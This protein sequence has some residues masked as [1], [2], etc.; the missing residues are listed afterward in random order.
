MSEDCSCVKKSCCDSDGSVVGDGSGG[1]G[2]LSPDKASVILD[3][4]DGVGGSSG[5]DVSRKPDKLPVV[6]TTLSFKDIF[7]A[8]K[9]RWGIGRMSYKVE[10]GL[11][12]VGT[13]AGDSPVLVSANYKL[14]FDTLRQNLSG[15][16]CWLLI[17]D[18]KGVNVW[19]AAGKGTFGTD[20]LVKRV[21]AVGLSEIVSHRKLILP[22]LGASGVNANEIARR[23]GFSVIFGPVR[24]IDIKE[25]I[26]S[27]YKAT[28][29]M[30]TVTF[31]FKDRIVLTPMELVPA[32]KKSFPIFGALFLTNKIAKRPFDKHDAAAYAGAVLAGAVAAP[33]LLPVIPGKAFAWKGWLV[34]F[35]WTA[36]YLLLTKRFNRGKRLLSAGELLLFPAVSSYLAMNSTGSSTYTSPSGVK[37]EMKKALPFIV[38]AGAVGAAIMLGVHL[39]GG[40]KSK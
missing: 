6:S 12:A 39:F 33:A 30:R 35:G 37:K 32:V 15:L 4:S 14:T 20:E 18:T 23:T 7:G 24:A 11:Y 10:P 28:K 38:G 8:W 21:E 2:S 29:E 16:D 5:F 17:L 19:C 9:V 36:K 40:E 13:P 31:T 22:Q 1:S 26:S 25:F 34:G 27:G 3:G